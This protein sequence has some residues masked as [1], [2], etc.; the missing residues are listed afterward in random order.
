M[1]CN[2]RTVLFADKTNVTGWGAGLAIFQPKHRPF[3]GT[4]FFVSSDPETL[5][6]TTTKG[7]INEE[8]NVW[9]EA[10]RQMVKVGHVITGLLD[11]RY[12]EDGQ[13]IAPSEMTN[14]SGRGITPSPLPRL[15]S[16]ENFGCRRPLT[17]EQY[18][19][20]TRLT[21]PI[22][23]RH[24]YLRRPGMGGSEIGRYTFNWFLK[25]VVGEDR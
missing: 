2:G 16:P 7:S 6:W 22:C 13:S 11:R 3:L 18:E 17:R 14:V 20:N 23:R 12:S 4:V 10:K 21:L 25:N 5:P 8:S 1:F 9:Q 19:Y 15:P 24:P